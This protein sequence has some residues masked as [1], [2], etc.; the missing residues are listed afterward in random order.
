[1][2]LIQNDGPPQKQRALY[3]F[4][5][6]PASLPLSSSNIS[7]TKSLQELIAFPLL[8]PPTF[9]SFSPS[10]TIASIFPCKQAQ[11]RIFSPSPLSQFSISLYL[12]IFIWV[13]T[14]SQLK[15]RQEQIPSSVLSFLSILFFHSFSP[16]LS[17]SLTISTLQSHS[18]Y[19]GPGTAIHLSPSHTL[20]DPILNQYLSY[21]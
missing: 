14:V 20:K 3:P 17:T 18:V 6:P 13:S 21:S 7:S 11:E 4:L 5:S 19:L 15:I 16:C 2:I 1:M 10:S 8:L 9:P 12:S